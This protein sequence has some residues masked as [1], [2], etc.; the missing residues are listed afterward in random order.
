MLPKML[1]GRVVEASS[2]MQVVVEQGYGVAAF[3]VFGIASQVL[4][5]AF[6]AARRWRPFVNSSRS[7]AYGA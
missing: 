7:S 3:V 1:L 5:V 2:E 6:F 4:L